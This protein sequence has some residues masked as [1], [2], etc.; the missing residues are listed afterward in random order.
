MLHVCAV[1]GYW[2]LSS[3]CNLFRSTPVEK[4]V[5]LSTKLALQSKHFSAQN[6]LKLTYRH[7][8]FQKFSRGET[9]GPPLK[10]KEEGK[11]REGKEEVTGQGIAPIRLLAQGP[12]TCK[13]GPG[14][15]SKTPN[16]DRRTDKRTDRQ[17]RYDGSH[18][19]A[20]VKCVYLLLFIRCSELF[21]ESLKL[22]LTHLHLAP[23]WDDP[24]ECHQDLC[25]PNTSSYVHVAH[26]FW[27]QSKAHIRRP[28]ND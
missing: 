1:H 27:Y 18:S 6:A 3:Q 9:P 2:Q 24:L 26:R 20:R 28:I 7:L 10:R 19:V 5:L 11:G 4:F 15:L 21:S 22:F 8:G 25:Q 17:T 13:S 23:N 12:R 16:C 14:H